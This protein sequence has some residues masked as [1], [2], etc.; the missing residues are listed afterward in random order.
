MADNYISGKTGSVLIGATPYSF[1]KWKLAMKTGLPKVTNF[2]T[3]GYQLLVSGI[4]AGTITIEGPYNQ[5]NMAFA[6]GTS[7]T[8]IL[9]W[10]NAVSI[11]VTAF[12]ESI[13][14]STD[15]EQAGHV[16]I[17]AQSSGTFTAA[18]T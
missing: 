16:V 9:G 8:F 10:T 5:S 6:C 4:T 13:E 14:A 12:I 17:T 2:T 1:G 11:T 15:V 3:A 7:Y 18:I